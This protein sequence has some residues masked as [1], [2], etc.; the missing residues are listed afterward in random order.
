MADALPP[1]VLSRLIG[2]IYDCVLDPA[3]WERTLADAR[4]AFRGATA[5]L[6][7]MDLRNGRRLITKTVGMDAEWLERQERY[8]PE[9]SARLTEVLASWPSLDEPFVVSRHMAS[10]F[11]ETSPYFQEHAI[12]HGLVDIMQLFLMRT[13]TRFAGFGIG[14]HRQEGVITEREIELGRLLAPHIRRAVLITDVLDA[15]T[16]ERTRMTEALDALRCAVVLTDHG[17]RILHAN[18]AAD[19]MLRDSGMIQVVGGTMRARGVTAAAELRDA[20]ALA[21]KDE[22]K[23]G[24]TGI[25]IRLTEPGTPPMFAH[26]LPLTGGELRTRLEPTAAAAVFIGVADERGAADV[27]TSAFGL[28]PAEHRVLAGLLA[29][30]TVAETAAALGTAATTARTHLD[31]IFA[32]TGVTR[33]AELMRLAARIGPPTASRR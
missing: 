17:G 10:S 18:R 32:K 25:S 2:S 6:D 4:D 21:A 33:Q 26:V 13:P 23:M 30:R 5:F 22:V 11:I 28:T 15:R 16:V 24:K 7:L 19:A 9:I 12:P 29:G 31:S 27:M 8:M 14:R 20:I 1:Q 3:R